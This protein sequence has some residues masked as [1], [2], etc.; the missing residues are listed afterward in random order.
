MIRA[1]C[2]QLI[3]RKNSVIKIKVFLLWLSSILDYHL[4][5]KKHI[6]RVHAC[7][8][9]KLFC[10]FMGKNERRKKC[11]FMA[12]S[13]SIHLTCYICSNSLAL[14]P[15]K[16]SGKSIHINMSWGKKTKKKKTVTDSTYIIPIDAA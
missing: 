12:A 4:S 16:L 7:T 10:A 14:L 9:A 6:A 3:D 13:L 5:Y 11:K 8:Y 1:H 15:G 2:P